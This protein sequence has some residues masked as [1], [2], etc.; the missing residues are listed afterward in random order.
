MLTDQSKYI[1]DLLNEI[2]TYEKFDKYKPAIVT[3]GDVYPNCVGYYTTNNDDQ[4]IGLLYIHSVDPVPGY[5]TRFVPTVSIINP[6]NIVNIR[7]FINRC[8]AY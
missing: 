8:E 2:K 4:N 1:L 6:N 7:A 5:M 3:R